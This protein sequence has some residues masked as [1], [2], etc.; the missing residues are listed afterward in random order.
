MTQLNTRLKEM[1]DKT[2]EH[3]SPS[4]SFGQIWD[5]HQVKP[6]RVSARK[7]PIL[8]FGTTFILMSF[9]FTAGYASYMASRNIDKTDYSFI[10]DQRLIGR[11]QSVDFV[12]EEEMFVPGKKS[13][14]T[15]LYL[16]DLIF[17]KD[18]KMLSA[19]ENGNLAYTTFSWTRDLIIS[20]QEGT[21]S[22][23]EI[24]EMNNE[25]YLLFQWKSGDYV[26][27]NRKPWYYV[28][29]KVDSEDYSNYNVTQI[30]E[31]NIE[32]P[33]VDNIQM[34]G[35]WK[36]V[37][38]VNSEVHFKPGEKS[39]LSDL[40]LTELKFESDGKLII[41]TTSGQ[42]SNKEV[43]WTKDL[44]LSKADKT[45]SLCTIKELGGSTYMFYEWKSGDYVFR[46]SKPMYYVL[47]KVD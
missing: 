32:Y 14:G 8:V 29:K 30:R 38:F 16:S 34:K 31:D 46:G 12:K 4:V 28:L 18:G 27:R 21:S 20:K 13:W 6:K 19:V 45:A 37:D 36:S 2:F 17:I 40:F 5:A 10:N 24:K 26:F 43:T 33:F 39:W 22:A 42:Y 11:W 23:Y 25:T 41:S 1:L 7:R 3:H 35:T 47:K 15:D 9:L 44:I